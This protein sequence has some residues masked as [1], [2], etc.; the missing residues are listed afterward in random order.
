MPPGIVWPEV[1]VIHLLVD[2]FFRLEI[3]WY[4]RA[5]TACGLLP[6]SIA[7]LSFTNSCL[8]LEVFPDVDVAYRYV[9]LLYPSIACLRA[10]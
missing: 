10:A 6:S 1:G 9:A 7:M 4:T 5:A 8:T 2:L 3:S